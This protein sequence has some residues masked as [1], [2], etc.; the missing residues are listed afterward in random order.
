MN[1]LGCFQYGSG[2]I[3]T[4]SSQTLNSDSIPMTGISSQLRRERAISESS[5][6]LSG[7]G[8][9]GGMELSGFNRSKRQAGLGGRWQIAD[10][11]R[12]KKKD[13]GG[14]S[15]FRHLPSAF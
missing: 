7:T 13:G 10:G 4:S 9:S 11:R 5:S 12:Q 1:A 14:T 15:A 2:L 6:C 8:I 3:S